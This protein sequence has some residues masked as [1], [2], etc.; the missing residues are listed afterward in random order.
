MKIDENK[1]IACHMAALG[2]ESDR[3]VNFWNI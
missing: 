2:V 3:M 1:N